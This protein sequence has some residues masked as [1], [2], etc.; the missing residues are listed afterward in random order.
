MSETNK[1]VFLSYASQDAEA[2]ERICE[3]LRAAGIEVWFDQSELRGGDAWD[4]KIRQQIRDCA[5]FLPVISANA[6]SRLEGYFRLEW[7]LAVDRTH[8]MAT[9]KAFLIPLVID[10]IVER[11]AH[12]P[13]SF[14]AVQWTRLP[15]GETPP[16]FVERLARL[17]AAESDTAPATKPLRSP[18][19][20]V[21]RG[22]PSRPLSLFVAA[23]AVLAAGYFA[24]DKFVLS[25]RARAEA[26]APAAMVSVQPAPIANSAIS[27]RS[28]AVLPFENMS[29]DKEQEYFS[30]GLTEE[31]LDLL[32]K[33]PDLRVPARTSSFSFKGKSEDIAAIAQKLRVAHVL[34]GSVRKS[35][36]RIRVTAELIRADSGYHVWSETYDRDIKDV[37]KV[38][39][40][41]AGAVVA[42]L[43]MKLAP[44]QPAAAARTSIAEAHN[45]YLLGRQ[46]FERVTENGYRRAV[47]AFQ[48]AIALDPQYA[49]AYAEL[50]FAECYLADFTGDAEGFHRAEAFADRAVALA[51]GEADGYAARG[52][53]RYNYAWD[54]AGAQSDFARALELDPNNGALLRRYGNLLKSLGRLPESIAIAKKSSEVDPLSAPTWMSLGLGLIYNKNF[55][56]AHEAIRRGLEIQPEDTFGLVSLIELLVFEHR[57]DEALATSRKLEDE[58]FRLYGVTLAE[59]ALGHTTQAQQALDE[60]I[61]KHARDS[62][63]Q[64]GSVFASFGDKD[65]AFEWL[66]RSYQQ[67]DGGLSF[68]KV[69]PLLEHLRGEA[70]YK[71]L[72][73]RMNLPEA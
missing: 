53:L 16:A 52:F 6:A 73:R 55:P 59:H 61:A 4:H 13:D 41:I 1:A 44:I 39:D 18:P 56:E 47:A 32:A 25:K 34:E 36:N 15:A 48:K 30:D 72:V 17:L 69:E 64:I 62:A 70:R 65:K 49:A 22:K 60:L 38:Q 51:P 37:F 40:E 26:Q 24:L 50:A 35:G 45:E 12:V 19:A 10:G 46:F 7:K 5:L 29:S 33:V 11:E 43:K 28:I 42:A 71:A 20:A 58:G 68:V 21:V 14:R 67:H 31:L 63:Y 2:A 57:A 9:E 8:L 54:W 23:L 3:A 66:E 27:E